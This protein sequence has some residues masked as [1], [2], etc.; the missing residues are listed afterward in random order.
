MHLFHNGKMRCDSVRLLPV[1]IWQCHFTTLVFRSRCLV[2]GHCHSSL[3]R[4]DSCHP[5]RIPPIPEPMSIE[6]RG[7]VRLIGPYVVVPLCR[8][9]NL[10][11]EV[12]LIMVAHNPGDSQSDILIPHQGDKTTEFL[13]PPA[14]EYAERMH[15]RLSTSDT[16]A[17]QITAGCAVI[18]LRLSRPN[19]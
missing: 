8:G 9:I 15:K 16:E 4:P 10:F 2:V 7:S 18:Y 12:G 11:M 5:C 19:L 14:H 1:V 6:P 17:S 13:A 3:E